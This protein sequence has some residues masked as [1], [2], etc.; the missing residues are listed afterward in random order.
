MLF[1]WMMAGLADTEDFGPLHIRRKKHRRRLKALIDSIFRT[2]LHLCGIQPKSAHLHVE[3]ARPILLRCEYAS[4][5]CEWC[6]QPAVRQNP[7][8][9]TK[10]AFKYWSRSKEVTNSP[11]TRVESSVY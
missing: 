8:L 4:Q 5:A 1:Q 6:G 2:G 10:C 11:R 9:Y 3:E 7:T